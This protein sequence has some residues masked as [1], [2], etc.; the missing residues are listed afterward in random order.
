MTAARLLVQNL[1]KS[2]AAPVLNDVSLTVAGGEIHALV[3]ENGAGKST[4][5]NILTGLVEKRS[6]ELLLDGRVYDPGRASDAFAAGV[7]FAA[8]ELTTI[9]TLSVAENIGLR[10]LPSHLSVVDG[11]GLTE[12]AQRLLNVVG[13]DGVSPA[14]KVERLSLA[15]RQ[16]IELAKALCSDSRLLILDEPTAAL[17]APQADRLHQ[18]IRDR[19]ASGTSVIYISHR[20]EDVLAIAD[21]VSVLRDGRLVMS[22]AAS[23][24]TVED[25]V[26]SMAGEVFQKRADVEV[27]TP[28]MTPLITADAITSCDLPEPIS[29]TGHAGEII[30]IAGLA[31]AGRSELLHALFGLTPLSSGVVTRTKNGEQVVLRSAGQAVKTGVAFLGEDR[32]AMGLFNGQS[33]LA[34]MMLPGKPENASPLRLVDRDRELAAAQ[35]LEN[36]LDIRCHGLTQDI[37][38]LSGGNQQK[39]LIGRW[40]NCES[41]VFLL[42]EPTRGVDVGTKSAIYDL[43]FELQSNGKCIL[44]A[45]SE[46]EELTTVCSRIVVMSGRKLV[47]T[48]ERGEWS[49]TEILTAAFQEFTSDRAAVTQ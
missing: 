40:L 44:L 47:Q 29:L 27:A 31:G 25:L 8:Q 7:S 35:A 39:A 32:Q 1:N 45:S 19:A 38:E 20:L 2:Y 3:G 12:T 21:T 36:K 48:F 28:D 33:V 4:L 18:I 6:G 17:T 22:Q 10:S 41:D 30:G 9:D 24:L 37:A 14:T 23:S 26:E 43:L 46:I 34:N 42:D 16:M 5:V 15:E 13:L 49:E 11:Q